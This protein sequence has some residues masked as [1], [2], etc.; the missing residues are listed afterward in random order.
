[1]GFV[2][3]P[4]GVLLVGQPFSPMWLGPPDSSYLRRACFDCHC[5]NIAPDEPDPP[6]VERPVCVV[7]VEDD[8]VEVPVPSYPPNPQCGVVTG[9]YNYQV[10]KHDL[11]EDR[12]QCNE[13]MYG[14]PIYADCEVAVEELERYQDAWEA[15]QPADDLNDM[16]TFVGIG[17]M[18]DFKR[19]YS[20]D[21]DGDNPNLIQL[22]VTQ[23]NGMLL[24]FANSRNIQSLPLRNTGTCTISIMQLERRDMDMAEQEY[25]NYLFENAWTVIGNCVES[26]GIGGWIEAGKSCN[27]FER[28]VSLNPNQAIAQI[29]TKPQWGSSFMVPTPGSSDFSTS[30]SHARRMPKGTRTVRISTT[31]MTTISGH[32]KNRNRANGAPK[33]KG[34]LDKAVQ[35]TLNLLPR[36][37]A[38]CPAPTHPTA[39][40]PTITSAPQPPL[41]PKIHPS[42]HLSERSAAN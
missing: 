17:R 32:A 42:T 15:A 37:S 5:T 4:N 10:D 23:T 41:Y 25:W 20:A 21:Y 36:N 27:V 19:E 14:R 24:C 40:Q 34:T 6:A 38:K 8:E 9:P 12:Y 29:Q 33:A 7:D 16:A 2:C 18:A 31:M 11:L 35:V 30:S 1:M 28:T 26:Q 39:T 22:P 3:G 13:Y